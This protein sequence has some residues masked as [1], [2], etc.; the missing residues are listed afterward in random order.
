MTGLLNFNKPGGITSHHAVNMLR[1]IFQ[2]RQ[3]GHTG[4]LDPMARG[5]LPI[6]IGSAVKASEWLV[7]E[8]KTYVAGLKLGLTAD[9]E[10]TTGTILTT[11]HDIPS[12]EQVLEVANSFL[13]TYHQIPPLYSA[14]KVK[15]KKLYEYAR[16]GKQIERESRPVEIYSLSVQPGDTPA[17]YILTVSCSKGTFIRTLCADIGKKLGCGGVMSCLLRTAAGKCRI[18]DSY[19]L[20]DL[21]KLKAENNLSSALQPPEELFADAPDIQLEPFYARLAKN[22]AE[23]YISKARLPDFPL[24]QQVRMFD[25]H[26]VFFAVGETLPYENGKAVKVRKFFA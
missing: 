21:E 15:G 11:S 17:D 24:G 1:R 14:I 10:D 2:T 12:F 13:G 8:N 26:G 16:E 22:G 25:E 5:V 3:V 23:I 20:E 19:T 6:L 9:T 7:A 4:T 18:E